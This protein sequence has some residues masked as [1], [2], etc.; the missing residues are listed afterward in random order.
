[1]LCD[2]IESAART[3]ADPTP[4]RLEQLVH[5]MATKRLMDGQFDE[6]HLTLKE[7]QQIETAVTKTLCAIYHSRV[8][9]PK[10]ESRE[11]QEGASDNHQPETKAVS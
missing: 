8:A 2:G 11:S 6:C 1:M 7:L 9:Y 3:I 5:Q 10:T 4:V